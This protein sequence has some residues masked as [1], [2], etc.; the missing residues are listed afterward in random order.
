[1]ISIKDK[2]GVNNIAFTHDNFVV[3]R[4]KIVEFCE[5]LLKCDEPFYWSCSARTDQV[6]DEL[7]ALMS[8][9]GCQGIF[10]GIETGSARLQGAIKKNLNLS[11]AVMRIQCADRHGIKIAVA[12]ITGFPEETKD[13]LKDTVSFFIDMFRFDNVDTQLSLLDPL[14]GTAIYSSYENKLILDYIYSDVSFQGKT[15]NADDLEMIQ[16]YPEVFPNFYSIPTHYMDRIYFKEAMDFVSAMQEWF[17]WLPLALNQD[18]GDMLNVFD[19]WRSW[20]A[21]KY[22]NSQNVD[23]CDWSYYNYRQFPKDFIEFVQTCYNDEMGTAKEVISAVIQIENLT[24]NQ[25]REPAASHEE[26]GTL[27]LASFPYKPASLQVAQLNLD[28]KELLSS[29]RN[30][31]NLEQ[32]PRNKVTIALQEGKGDQIETNVLL[33][34]PLSEEILSMCDGGHTVSDIIYRPSLSKVCVDNISH[35]KVIFFGLT[36]LFKQGLIEVSSLPIE[37][38]NGAAESRSTKTN[39]RNE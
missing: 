1:M 35:E 34:S 19:R 33:L 16:T 31:T 14:V 11:D 23:A 15:Q 28:Y 27:S 17:R 13:D 10:F 25:E 2:Y 18:S 3:D 7:I 29:L 21:A 38:Q 9:A 36:Q 5:T 12:L 39:C 6:D 37:E 22:K 30:K 24:L 20:R 32:V 26:R 4:K 8:K